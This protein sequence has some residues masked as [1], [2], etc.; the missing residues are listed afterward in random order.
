MTKE[1]KVVKPFL[2]MEPGDTLTLSE[3]GKSYVSTINDEYHSDSDGDNI[4]STYTSTFTISVDQAKNMIT[5][6]LL[7]EVKEKS[8]FVNIFDEID[9]LLVLYSKDL[10]SVDTTCKDQPACLKTERITVLNNL[11]KLLNHLKDLK[12]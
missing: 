7:R 11:I 8:K 3:D 5:D 1:L 2:M 10:A 12:L 6:G 4:W 9:R